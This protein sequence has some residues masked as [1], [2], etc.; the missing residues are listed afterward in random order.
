MDVL[1]IIVLCIGLLTTGFNAAMFIVV[2]F[3][4]LHHLTKSVEEIKG[5]ICNLDTKIDSLGE[6]VSRLEGKLDK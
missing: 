3:N 2:K 4:D 5:L 1:G 6:R